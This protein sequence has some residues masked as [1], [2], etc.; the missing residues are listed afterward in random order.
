MLDVIVSNAPIFLLVAV[1]CFA[2]IQTLPLLSG[3]SVPRVARI[4]L[5]GYLA[6]LILP[7]ALTVGWNVDAYSLQYLLLLIG[8]GLIGI[9]IGF[10]VS[11][12][13]STFSSAGQF[14]TYQ[15]GFGASQ[16]YDALSKVQNPVMG[17]YFN[18]I[19][20]LLFLQSGGFQK[21]FLGGVLR[22]FQSFNAYA[23]VTHRD[24]F[25]NFLIT[26]LT[27]LFLDGMLMAL[28]IV[29]TLFL[30][31]V[32]MGILSKAA[33]QMNLLSEGLPITILVAFLLIMYLMPVLCEAFLAIFDQ[34]FINIE[35]LI[36]QVGVKI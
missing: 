28:P 27:H 8:E 26:G 29:G 11:I 34:A 36:T 5:A 21:L 32:C 1:R 25:L 2:M 14:F 35:D 12:I 19:A 15:M 33:P 6:F 24:D 17:Q 9:I 30:I 20:M 22:S 23:L 31:S 16:V 13:F 7:R 3:T 18:L 10:Y 4:A